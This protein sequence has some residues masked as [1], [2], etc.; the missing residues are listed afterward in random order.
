M[1]IG[2]DADIRRFTASPPIRDPR[3]VDEIQLFGSAHSI[4]C[5]VAM[6]DGS[7]RLVNYGIQA[8]TFQA[9]GNRSDGRLDSVEP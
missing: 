4:G 7:V 1:F 3:G 6:C 9:L 5:Y 8:E 2:D